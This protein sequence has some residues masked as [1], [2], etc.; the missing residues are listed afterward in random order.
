MKVEQEQLEIDKNLVKAMMDQWSLLVVSSK[1]TL[2]VKVLFHS[3]IH[4]TC[5]NSY[6]Q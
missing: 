4:L 6:I 2:C 1:D 3:F 5:V